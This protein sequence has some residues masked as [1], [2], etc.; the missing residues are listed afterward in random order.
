MEEPPTFDKNISGDFLFE[1]LSLCIGVEKNCLTAAVLLE[2]LF[3][4]A[5]EKSFA[6]RGGRFGNLR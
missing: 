5:A 2:I 6:T 4:L 1:M 3:V